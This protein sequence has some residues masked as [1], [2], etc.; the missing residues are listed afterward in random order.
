MAK[1]QQK[2][3]EDPVKSEL[4][5]IKRLLAVL[6]MKLGTS[7]GEVAKAMMIDPTKLSRMLPARE[8]KPFGSSE[9]KK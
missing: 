5:A 8:F 6:L 7:Q 9:G 1:T 2:S 3:V 4:E